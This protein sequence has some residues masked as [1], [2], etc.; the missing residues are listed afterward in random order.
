MLKV[1]RNGDRDF[2]PTLHVAFLAQF[3]YEASPTGID[4]PHSAVVERQPLC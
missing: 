3:K 1:Q 4:V 2:A